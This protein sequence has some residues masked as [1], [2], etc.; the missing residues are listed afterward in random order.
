MGIINEM[1][2]LR[3]SFT[4]N[5]RQL[6][7]G[8]FQDM[9]EGKDFVSGDDNYVWFYLL[10]SIVRPRVIAEMG[11]RFG[12]SLKCFVEGAGYP[13]DQ[14]VLRSFDYECD[15]IETLK[16]MEDYFKNVLGVQD[17]IVTKVDTQSIESL[18]L[19][20]QCD[21]CLVD[22]MHTVEGCRHECWMAWKALKSGGVMVVDDFHVDMPK[23]GL[24]I[25]CAEA[26]VT[27]EALNSFRGMAIIIKP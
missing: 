17:M 25:F 11:S 21:L 7:G 22:G 9:D 16:I 24:E 15:G 2:E 14:Y 13:M 8:L 4:K 1:L 20:G 12:Y 10:A 26:G 18:E 5:D 3:K 23:E 27:Y 19:D 6:I